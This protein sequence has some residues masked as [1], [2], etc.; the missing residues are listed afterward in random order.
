MKKLIIGLLIVSSLAL[1]SCEESKALKADTPTNAAYL[2]KLKLDSNNYE[3]VKELFSEGRR[4]FLTEEN[5]K[6]W[7]ELKT[8]GSSYVMYET[9]TFDD[10]E[11]LLV[12]ITPDKIDGEY[13]IEDVTIVPEEMRDLFNQI[14]LN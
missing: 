5:F 13:K 14:H 12:R 6:E 3:E 4:E 11:M 7:K 1:I 2:L 8:A 9:I 10:G